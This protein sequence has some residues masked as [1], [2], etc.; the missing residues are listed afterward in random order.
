MYLSGYFEG[1]ILISVRKHYVDLIGR[2]YTI[3]TIR[4]IKQLSRFC[5][6]RNT[7]DVLTCIISDSRG[8]LS[9]FGFCQ[10]CRIVLHDPNIT[11]LCH[12]VS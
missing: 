3:N 11:F 4:N 8:D 7:S 9:K 6:W 5:W 10:G 12:V 1:E 2:A